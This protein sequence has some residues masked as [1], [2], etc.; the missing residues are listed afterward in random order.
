MVELLSAKVWK[1]LNPSKPNPQTS[2][3]NPIVWQNRELV[4]ENCAKFVLMK[5]VWKILFWIVAISLV[6]TII[7]SLGYRFVESVFISTLFA[8]CCLFVCFYFSKNKPKKGKEYATNTTYALIDVIIAEIFL[9]VLAHYIINSLRVPAASY[10]GWPQLPSLMMNPI[11]ISVIIAAL[12]VGYWLFKQW[13]D[14]SCPAAPK[15]IV[16]LSSRKSIGLMPDEIIYVESNDTLTTV[17]ATEGRSFKNRNS[18]SQWESILEEGFVRTHRSFIINKSFI[19]SVDVDTI[20]L[21]GEIEIPI[22]R[23]Y[24]SNVLDLDMD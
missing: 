9:F 19:T 11:F 10:Y 17:Y 15:P 7:Q 20:Y 5:T 6:A 23:K 1:A 4:S 21:A 16:F 14:K 12:S 2:L 13:L 24:K 18:I 22:S 8:P 3:S